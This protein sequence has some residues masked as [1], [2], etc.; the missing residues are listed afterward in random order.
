MQALEYLDESKEEL[1]R[2]D[3][4]IYVSLKYTRTIDILLNAIARMIDAY[5]FMFQSLLSKAK[6]EQKIAEVPITPIEKGNLIKE[7]YPEDE[8]IIDNVELFFLLRKIH[9]SPNPEKEQEYRRHVTLRVYIGGREEIV[10]IDI[11]T[12]YYNFQLNFFKRLL[13]LLGVDNKDD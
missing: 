12:Q 7:L 13:I 5:D 1:K 3:H 6:E 2:V 8:Q 4:L 10:N 9:R 11:I